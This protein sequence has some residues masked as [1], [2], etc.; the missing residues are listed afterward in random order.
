[1]CADQRHALKNITNNSQ[2]GFSVRRNRFV[3]SVFSEQICSTYT[4]VVTRTPKG[5]DTSM[6][7]Q[8]FGADTRTT[9]C[10]YR[11]YCN[12]KS[13]RVPLLEK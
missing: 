6:V 11:D 13:Y 5:I 12:S 8:T 2:A 7:Y 3:F 9:D 10:V 4:T 1:M